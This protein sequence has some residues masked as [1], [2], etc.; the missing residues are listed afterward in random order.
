MADSFTHPDIPLGSSRSGSSAAASLPPP[1][2][3]LAA[4]ALPPRPL[5]VE[6]PYTTVP[7][8]A[9]EADPVVFGRSRVIEPPEPV[10]LRPSGWAKQTFLA[11]AVLA[12][13]VYYISSLVSPA[14]DEVGD[15]ASRV[16]AASAFVVFL[17]VV[18]L[19]WVNVDNCRRLLAH[20]RHRESISPW[21]AV[22]WWTAPLVVG[23]PLLLGV[24]LIDERWIRPEGVSNGDADVA[25]GF[26]LAGWFLVML[27]LWMRP[28]LYLSTVMKRIHA[29]PALFRRWFWMPILAATV[30]I[31][32]IIAAGFGA[33]ADDLSEVSPNATAII[34]FSMLPYIVWFWAGW[35][36]LS[37]MDEFVQARSARQFHQ[38]QQ[39]L[40]S[41]VEP[42]DPAA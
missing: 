21:R 29:E 11:A 18:L 19:T 1:T 16:A 17:A 25:Y 35:R 3:A 24:E 40:E 4:P 27:I 14:A 31:F 5:E 28:Y 15:A 42:A 9:V 8:A 6:G 34:V 12:G 37:I 7:A 30:A 26:L 2:A 41:A 38:R 23:V 22:F 10:A 33:A 20:S 32:G 39:F 13:P 36:A